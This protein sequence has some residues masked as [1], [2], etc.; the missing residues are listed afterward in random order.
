MNMRNKDVFEYG[1]FNPFRKWSFYDT[2]PLN[3][4]ISDIIDSLQGKDTIRTII[5]STNLN[6][7]KLDIFELHNKDKR[8]QQDIL[9]ASS[10]IPIAFPPVNINGTL[11]VDGGLI[12][13]ENHI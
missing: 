11:Y 13:N 8:S 2:D 5:G 6:E 7:G 9:L 3:K 4:T 12:T 1:V 10:A